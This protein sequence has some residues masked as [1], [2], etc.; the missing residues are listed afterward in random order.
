MC[1]PGLLSGDSKHWGSFGCHWPSDPQVSCCAP[2]NWKPVLQVMFMVSPTWWTETSLP[3]FA[4][5][6]TTGLEHVIFFSGETIE[7][8]I[9]FSK[10]GS[11]EVFIKAICVF[12]MLN[13]YYVTRPVLWL[14][15]EPC[16]VYPSSSTSCMSLPAM[17][18]WY[19]CSFIFVTFVIVNKSLSF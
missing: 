14:I 12:N 13:I 3:L 9:N 5:L 6:F 19:S 4:E 18:R 16:G 7:L 15:N 1:L 10:E 11:M 8:V 2:S 17:E